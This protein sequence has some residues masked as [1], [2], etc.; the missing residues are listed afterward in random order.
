MSSQTCMTSFLCRTQKKVFWFTKEDSWKPNCFELFIDFCSISS[1]MLN[2]KKK[3]L[4]IWIEMRVSKDDSII[5][6]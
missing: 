3:V 1:F 4:Q 5:L 2:R 6:G